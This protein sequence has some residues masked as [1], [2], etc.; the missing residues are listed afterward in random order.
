MGRT[1]KTHTQT[2]QSSLKGKLTC[3]ASGGSFQPKRSRSQNQFCS[4]KIGWGRPSFM[5]NQSQNGEGSKS[6]TLPP[7][8]HWKMC[9]WRGENCWQVGSRIRTFWSVFYT[10]YTRKPALARVNFPYT[11]AVLLEVCR[12]WKELIDTK[13]C[14]SDYKYPLSPLRVF[15]AKYKD[16]QIHLGSAILFT[17]HICHRT[18]E[19][20]PG[21]AERWDE[22]WKDMATSFECII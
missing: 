14:L 4:S 13:T 18:R 16:L 5:Q 20:F 9:F 6:G 10:K 8:C 2:Q 17:N 3:L 22:R 15:S 1:V 19:F 12:G 7:G 11:Y 21:F